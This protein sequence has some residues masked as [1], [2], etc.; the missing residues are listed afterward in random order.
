MLTQTVRRPE[1][2]M[3]VAKPLKHRATTKERNRLS[4]DADDAA[5]WVGLSLR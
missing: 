4:I 2:T 5:R 1:G 3:C